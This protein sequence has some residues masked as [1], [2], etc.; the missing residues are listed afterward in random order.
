MVHI[1]NRKKKIIAAGLLLLCLGLAYRFLPQ[2]QEIGRPSAEVSLKEKQLKKYRE[3]VRSGK[4]LEA[5]VRS[6]E[7]MIEQL[8]SG[9]LSGKTSALAAV[10]VQNILNGIATTSG[11]EIKK[12]R[13]LKAEEMKR[14]EYVSVPVQFTLSTGIRQLKAILYG[15]EASN[16]YLRVEKISIKVP[17][18]A[19][20][21]AEAAVQADMTVAG[22]MRRTDEPV[23]T[24]KAAQK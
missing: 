8:E 1:D 17:R 18:L 22:I 14:G 24:Q 23:S 21:K 20:Q 10:D 4:E 13:V 5:Q 19:K 3:L 9:L 6:Q 16:K 7:Q 11:T 15:I 12:V 2:F